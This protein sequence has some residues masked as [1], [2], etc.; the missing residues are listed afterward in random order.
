MFEPEIRE[1][2]TRRD[3]RAYLSL[4]VAPYADEPAFVHPDTRTLRNVLRDRGWL[5]RRSEHTSFLARVPEEGPVA[6]LSVFLHESFEEK[7]G[8]K[9]ATIGFLEA[10]PG[11]AEAVDELFR[12]A[13]RWARDHGARRIRGPMNG[14]IMYGFGCLDDAYGEVPVIGTAYNRNDY[15][16]HWWRQQYAKAPS[17]YSYRIDLQRPEVREVIERLS[18]NPKL[19]QEPRITI[20][21]ADL[22]Q[23]RREVGIF[24]DLHNEAFERNWSDTPLTH[25]EAWELMGL[26]RYTTDP[27]LFRIAEIEGKP[28]GVVLCMD[29]LNQVLHGVGREPASLRA[30]IALLLHRR[31][32]RRGAL[33]VI[34][35][36][37][38]ARGRRLAETLAAQ[39]LRR[40]VERGF[41]EV[42]YC[43]VLED[44]APS[45]KIARRFGG[46]HVKTYRMFEKQLAEG[47]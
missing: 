10:R 28:V 26:A 31:K 6:C 39:A 32:I 18:V 34:G 44:N 41:T 14:H 22:S 27:E 3:R 13:E 38:E 37:A 20:R 1:V 17:Y 7:Y 19:D 16:G 21:P 30:G 33:H 24:I 43:L 45:Q 8:E 9:I 4:L 5:A 29:D 25:D 42:E 11:H 35:V 47:T 23:W 12:A 46:T 15:P 2:R 36:L 40:F